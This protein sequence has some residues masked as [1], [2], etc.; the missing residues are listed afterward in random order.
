[1]GSRM[2]LRRTAPKRSYFLWKDRNR[3]GYS[4]RE[5]SEKQTKNMRSNLSSFLLD[6]QLRQIFKILGTPNKNI[7]PEFPELPHAKTLKFE[8]IPYNTLP[9]RFP[10]GATTK[11]CLDLLNRMLCYDPKKR[12]TAEEA[13]KH[14][15]FQEFPPPKHPSL[16][17]TWP[18]KAAGQ[19]R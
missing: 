14:D 6:L 4:P 12:I 9:S 1:V 5:Q 8:N 7:W 15:F 3:T 10:R 13:L 11:A 2:H 16:F 19:K 17:P 18:S